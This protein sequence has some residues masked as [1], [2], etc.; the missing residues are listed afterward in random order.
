M[1]RQRHRP[2][3]RE[4]RQ[5]RDWWTNGGTFSLG[6]AS[7]CS[8][9]RNDY[10]DGRDV[11]LH[12][13][14]HTLP[15]SMRCAWPITRAMNQGS[16]VDSDHFRF[17]VPVSGTWWTSWCDSCE[18][19]RLCTQAAEVVI[20]LCATSSCS[21]VNVGNLHVQRRRTHWGIIEFSSP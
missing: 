16:S 5:T 2:N 12:E 8:E 10:S 4:T 15:F 11:Q 20:P 3:V 1:S 14:E 13:V 9:E 19:T 18:Q 21:A 7:S 17:I 6:V